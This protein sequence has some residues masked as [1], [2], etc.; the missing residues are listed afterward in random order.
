MITETLDIPELVIPFYRGD[1]AVK[2]ILLASDPGTDATPS[3]I[4]ATAGSPNVTINYSS[5]LLAG[6]T[7]YTAD[8]DAL[9]IGVIA[10][11]GSGT[12]T[13]TSNA[14]F[15]Y[16]G[17]YKVGI[18]WE[19][20]VDNVVCELTRFGSNDAVISLELGD[21]ITL[22][23]DWATLDF[24]A[25]LTQVRADKYQGDFRALLADGVTVLTLFQIITAPFTQ[26]RSQQP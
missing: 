25:T 9:V 18:G 14:T 12:A 20:A 1:T 13:L 3:A 22:D 4:V 24:T 23:G 7:L 10:S 15:S 6:M 19:D 17:A 5:L 16:S 11:V 8:S 2:R 21:G 26:N